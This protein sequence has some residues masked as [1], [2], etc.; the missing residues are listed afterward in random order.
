MAYRIGRARK[1]RKPNIKRLE[2]TTHPSSAPSTP[3][4]SYEKLNVNTDI[5]S[6]K[7]LTSQTHSRT[8]FSI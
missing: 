2:N 7:V 4:Y 3:S 6:K 5:T 1:L 8:I